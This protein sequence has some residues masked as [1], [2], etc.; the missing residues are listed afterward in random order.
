MPTIHDLLHEIRDLDSLPRI[1]KLRQ[2]HFDTRPAVCLELPR[3]MT[4]YLKDE[5]DPGDSAELRAGKIYQ[6]L[7]ERKEAVFHDDNLLAGST[8]TKPKGVMLYP[9]GFALSIWSELETMSRRQQNPF[10][11][12][13]EELKD[14]IKELNEDI[15]PFWIDAT[16]YERARKEY[17]NPWCQQV[18]ERIIF[19]LATKAHVISHTI[20]N[21]AAVVDRGL[22]EI[23]DE[24]RDKELSLGNTPLDQGKR[25]FYRAVQLSLQGVLVYADKLSRQ[26][27]DEARKEGISPPR[28]DELLKMGRVCARVPG[29]KPRSFR[30]AVNAIWICKVALHQ[31]GTNIALSPGRLDQVLY[32]AFS[33]ELQRRRES[34]GEA[35]ERAF[36]REA[37]ELVC[38]LWL[39]ICDHVPLAPEASEQLFGGSGSNQA[40]TLGGVDREG[41][42]AVNDLT[43]VML[44]ATELLRLRDPNVN[45]RYHPDVHGRDRTYLNRLCEVNI[46]TGATPCFHNDKAVI[47]TLEGQGVSPPD[48]RDYGIV[49]CVEPE[50]AGRT[51]GHPGAIAFNLAAALELALFQGKHRLT[52]DEQISPIKT[53]AP[54]EML[55]FPEFQEAFRTQLAWLIDQAV[56]MNDNLGRMYQRHHPF[57]ILSALMEGCLKKG[58]DV[59]QGGAVY[60]SSGVWNI[61]LAEVVDSLTAIEEFVFNPNNPHR[62]SFEEMLEAVK[63]NWESNK[64]LQARVKTHA[65]KFGAHGPLAKRNAAWLIKFLH[66][67]FQSKRNY[68][69]GSY[70]SGYYSMTTHAGFGALT[71]ALPSGRKEG[72]P[73]PSG[74]TPASGAAPELADVLHFMAGLDHRHITNGQALNLKFPPDTPVDPLAAIYAGYFQEGGLQVQSNLID[75]QTLLDAQK[76][77]ANPDYR[78]LF[79]RVSGYSAYFVDLN[80]K[81]Q[82]EIITRTT[83]NLNTLRAIPDNFPAAVR[84][85]EDRGPRAPNLLAG[86]DAL[87]QELTDGLSL[88]ESRRDWG[89]AADRFRLLP[90]PEKVWKEVV[91]KL[92]DTIRYQEDIS[93]EAFLDLLLFAMQ[94]KFAIDGNY[95]KNIENFTGSYFFYSKDGNIRVPVTFENGT[96]R[97]P[98]FP[99]VWERLWDGLG[100]WLGARSGRG[101]GAPGQDANATLE[102]RDGRALRNYLINY[103]IYKDRNFLGSLTRNEIRP[104]GNLNYLYKF[105]FMAN[106]FLL[107]VSDDLPDE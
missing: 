11:I 107:E 4:R 78:D 87:L 10:D 38:C 50:S 23:I 21:Y 83:Y 73:L 74:I 29:E 44:K 7:L 96:V 53:K 99:R 88:E 16:L 77:P 58:R 59:I 9:D 61:G 20:P 31:E 64:S 86:F 100:N 65:D 79:V 43:Y 76:N 2:L 98:A 39:K 25:D 90:D 97:R 28:R 104:G 24:A 37:V 103:V 18:L 15:L 6:Y 57:P 70:A 102:F 60:N 35:G 67:T 13:R 14:E 71:G 93:A 105:L 66:D 106:H 27:L 56:M 63:S 26:A 36:L 17:G 68:R 84:E 41:N 22:R 51:F 40:V 34:E 94:V 1:K 54:Q 89:R 69:G 101:N 12:S 81:M 72:E 82:Q 19:F 62:V 33:D 47:E 52:Q 5:D 48:A 45:A 95:R 8:T 42:D 30:E 49:G 46:K 92:L 80:P 3:L 85:P 55:A 91:K 32:P 75:L